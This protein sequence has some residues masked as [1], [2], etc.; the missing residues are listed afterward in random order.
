MVNVNE[1]KELLLSKLSGIQLQLERLEAAID[2]ACSGLSSQLVDHHLKKLEKMDAR[3]LKAE[4]M[5]GET[6]ITDTNEKR[7][8]ACTIPKVEFGY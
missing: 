7:Q 5:A 1:Q 4:E 6:S 3:I 8:P 2:D